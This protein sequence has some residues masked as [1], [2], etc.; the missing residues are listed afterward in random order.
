VDSIRNYTGDI[1]NF[2]L[3]KEQYSALHPE[4]ADRIKFVVVGE[5]V[6]V[7]KTQGSIVGRRYRVHGSTT[8]IS[9]SSLEV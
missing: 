7:G 8:S 6:A 5:D 4:K 1:L 9:H 3:S 2:G